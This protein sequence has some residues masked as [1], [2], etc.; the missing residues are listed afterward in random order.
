MTRLGDPHSEPRITALV[1]LI[2]SQVLGAISLIGWAVGAAFTLISIG[3]EGGVPLWMIAVWTYPFWMVALFGLSWVLFLKRRYRTA[4]V[5][6]FL[7]L[8][9][10]AALLA[11]G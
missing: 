3:G 1:C 7:P 4:A 8:L 10:V 6:T 5:V 11:V 2:A 9:P